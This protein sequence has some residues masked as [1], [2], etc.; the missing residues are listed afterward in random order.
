MDRTRPGTQTGNHVAKPR[1]GDAPYLFV[2]LRCD[3]PLE[4][5]ARICL[6]RADEVTVGRASALAVRAEQ[7]A[8]RVDV[9]DVRVSGQHLRISRVLGEWVLEDLKS[10]N[11]TLLDGSRVDRIGIADGALIEAGQTFFIFRTALPQAGN[12]LEATALETPTPGLESLVPCNPG[13]AK[14]RCCESAAS[15]IASCNS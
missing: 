3:R 1:R 2:A 14:L 13:W 12:V 6:G 4:G 9:P 8:L 10:R 5:A 7:S 11:G 15:S